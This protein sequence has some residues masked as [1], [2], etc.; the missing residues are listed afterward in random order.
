MSPEQKIAALRQAILTLKQVTA[1]YDGEPREFCPHFLGTQNAV[2]KVLAWQFAGSSR[3]GLR[4]GGD[5]R[6]F[7]LERLHGLALRDGKWHR[8]VYQ[9]FEQHCVSEI[10]TAVDAEHGAI[11]PRRDK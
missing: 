4:P 5:W 1:T 11:I 7:A 2:W 10:D 8:G 3:R 9:G 6:C